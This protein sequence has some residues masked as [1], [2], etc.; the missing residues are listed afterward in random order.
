MQA[1]ERAAGRGTLK[2]LLGY[3][4]GVGKSFRMFDEGRRRKQRGQ[5]VVVGAVQDPMVRD[6]ATGSHHEWP[7]E[8]YREAAAVN[9]LAQRARFFIL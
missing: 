4:P 6:W 5:D 1:A 8:A 3:A 9:S 7:S 2:I